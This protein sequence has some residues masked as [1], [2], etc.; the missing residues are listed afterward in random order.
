MNEIDVHN[1]GSE[2]NQTK[3][4]ETSDEQKQPAKDLEYGD[5]VKVMAQEKRL[6]EVSSSPGG[7]G[8]MGMKCK[9]MFDPKTT[10]MSPSRIRA[11]I[12]ATFI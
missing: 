9:K 3:R 2:Q 6:S 10:K 4:D 8:G 5:N 7:G 11:I 1:Y 12:V